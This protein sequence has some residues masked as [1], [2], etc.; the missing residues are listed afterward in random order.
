M[1]I[2]DFVFGGLSGMIGTSVIQPIDTVK[3]RIQLMGESKGLA[4]GSGGA[5]GKSFNTSPFAI[6]RGI[7]AKEGVK[8]FYRGIDSALFRQA[9]YCTARLG[10]Y[11]TIYNKRMEEKGRVVFH[12]KALISLVSGFLG[13]LIGNPSDLALVRFQ[14]DMYLPEAERRNYRNVFHAFTRIGKYLKHNT[15]IL[16]NN[17]YSW[18]KKI[19]YL[20]SFDHVKLNYSERGRSADSLERQCSHYWKSHVHEPGNAHFL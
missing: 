15:T 12:E 11:K 4:S 10:I 17:F 3:V 2:K 9:T 16:Q 14:S 13:S 1:S 5:G 18:L 8:G 6:A 20:F 7:L 19:K